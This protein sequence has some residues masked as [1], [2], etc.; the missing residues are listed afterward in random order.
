MNRWVKFVPVMELLKYTQ[1]C[2]KCK[3]INLRWTKQ[4]S[5]TL[6]EFF[7]PT[8]TA[9]VSCILARDIRYSYLRRLPFTSILTQ[10]PTT[11]LTCK[12]SMVRSFVFLPS[13][14]H[15]FPSASHM[16]IWVLSSSQSRLSSI[17]NA[18][19]RFR[20]LTPNT[21]RSHSWDKSSAE[22]LCINRWQS[23]G[24][25]RLSRKLMVMGSSPLKYTK[26]A[27]P[28]AVRLV[29]VSLRGCESA[30]TVWTAGGPG[31][32]ASIWHIHI[33]KPEQYTLTVYIHYKSVCSWRKM[34]NL[35]TTLTCIWKRR[36]K[37]YILEERTYGTVVSAQH[38]VQIR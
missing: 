33:L 15:L 25:A 16:S 4:M 24:A 23:A 10:K 21:T 35:V 32:S 20:L 34:L 38:A 3:S 8:K 29:H 18:S 1:K 19:T 26:L 22:T 11:W 12:S 13:V 36:T 37:A 27:N 6:H 9:E 5:I 14:V 17:I 28:C 30:A 31:N 2:L 7:L